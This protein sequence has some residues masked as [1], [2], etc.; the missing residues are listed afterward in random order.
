M[1]KM[2]E[3]RYHRFMKFADKSIPITLEK[4]NLMNI[5][6]YTKPNCVQCTQTKKYFEKNEIS[7]VTLDVMDEANYTYVT[8]Q[9]NIRS[10]PVIV[11]KDASGTLVEAW[12]G[13]DPE[14]L[15]QLK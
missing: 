14:R 8:E 6:F 7:Y 13:Y 5:E 15:S 12:G 4:D 1:T 3:I 9:L 10:A 11:V 2:L